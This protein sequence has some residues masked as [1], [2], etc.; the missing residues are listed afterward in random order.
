M[1]SGLVSQIKVASSLAR[2]RTNLLYTFHITVGGSWGRYVYIG[3]QDRIRIP[4]GVE[5]LSTNS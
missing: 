4:V 1:Y 3:G 5:P 2:V